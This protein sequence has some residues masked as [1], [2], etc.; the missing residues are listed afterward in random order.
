MYAHLQVSFSRAGRRVDGRHGELV[1]VGVEVYGELPEGGG[2]D[3]D[4][5]CRR[6]LYTHDQ[7]LLADH[8]RVCLA[9]AESGS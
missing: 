3:V 8:A 2:V 5:V 9:A 4:T 7:L 1:V 6:V